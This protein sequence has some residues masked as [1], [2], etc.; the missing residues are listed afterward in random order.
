[1]P[2]HIAETAWMNRDMW[3]AS[4]TARLQTFSGECCWNGNGCIGYDKPGARET[5][6][7]RSSVY[8]D[9]RQVRGQTL[10]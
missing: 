6:H 7:A 4:G 9:Y 1:M 2:R 10:Y 8:P 3:T 5:K